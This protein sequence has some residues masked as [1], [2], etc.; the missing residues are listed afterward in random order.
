MTFTH[1]FFALATTAYILIGIRLEERDL[2]KLHPEYAEYRDQ[3]PMLLPGL[4][5][6]VATASATN[7]RRG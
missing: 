3:V 1:L 7:L 2:I 4:R 5:R 6:R